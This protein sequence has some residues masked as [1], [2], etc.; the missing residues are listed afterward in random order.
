MNLTFG[1]DTLCVCVCVCACVLVSLSVI[2]NFGR[3]WINILQALKAGTLRMLQLPVVQM[4]ANLS[5]ES[6]S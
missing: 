2:L 6:N 1:T 4:N 3:G 5:Q